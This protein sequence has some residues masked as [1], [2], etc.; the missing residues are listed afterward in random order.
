MV[1]RRRAFRA[2]FLD[3][4]LRDIW[5]PCSM[6]ESAEYSSL[7]IMKYVLKIVRM[8]EPLESQNPVRYC[9]TPTT[10]PMILM[11]RLSILNFSNKRLYGTTCT[12]PPGQAMSARTNC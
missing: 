4:S 9:R 10:R 7:A 6:P 12:S 3:E 8:V 1:A 2:W 11:S 5:M